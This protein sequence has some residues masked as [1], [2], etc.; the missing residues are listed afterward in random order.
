MDEANNTSY[1]VSSNIYDCNERTVQF[2]SKEK[3]FIATDQLLSSTKFNH[4]PIRILVDSV[5]AN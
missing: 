2:M 4:V 1:T 3:Y 5:G